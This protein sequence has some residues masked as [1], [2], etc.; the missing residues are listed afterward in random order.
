MARPAP[1]VL[2][3]RQRRQQLGLSMGLVADAIG[4]S[5]PTVMCWEHGERS[6]DAHMLD[7]YARAL[8]TTLDIGPRPD[9]DQVLVERACAG[10][11]AWA[12]LNRDERLAAYR[13]LRGQGW[14]LTAIR[15]H[16]HLNGWTVCE[17]E[18]GRVPQACRARRRQTGRAA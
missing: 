13:T 6:P 16:L 14:T 4:V 2:A 11:A 5:M 3:L 1:I 12:D 7:A 10:K 8:G 15:R 9:V 17:L 18:A